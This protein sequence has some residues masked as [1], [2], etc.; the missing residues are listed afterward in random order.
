MNISGEELWQWR[1]WAIAAIPSW[2]EPRQ[3]QIELDWLLQAVAE[4]D[5][6][7]LR[8][9]SYRGLAQIPLKLSLRELTDLWHR[10]WQDRIPM[11]YLVGEVP[12]RNLKLHVSPAVLIPRPETEE[13]IDLAIETVNHHPEL[14]PPP[15]SS[16]HWA[17]LGTGSGAIALGL[18]YSFPTA[19]IHA[20]DRSAAALEI[21]GR[22]RDRQDWGKDSGAGTLQERLQFYQ[23]DWL[24][25]LAKL[26]GH[27]TGIVSNPPYIPTE[28]L[29]ELER[30]V[31]EH[32]PSLALDGGA[33]GLTAIREIIETAADY[34]QPGGVLLLE[35]MSGQDQQVRQLLEQTGGYTDIQIHCDL[36]GIPRFAQ[37]FKKAS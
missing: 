29:D 11:Q 1:R 7:S 30:E 28:L 27:L 32:E 16:P 13:L 31:V 3:A 36:S 4:L 8:L 23:G 26:K 18:A 9:A 34:L 22:N 21:A 33:D 12:W 17:D 24:E 19:K 14:S 37:A 6:L 20:V 25:P 35:M 15:P 5:T 2:L 10:R